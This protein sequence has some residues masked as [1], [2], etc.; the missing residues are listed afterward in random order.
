MKPE[1]INL[2]KWVVAAIGAVATFFVIDIGKLKLEKYKAKTQKEQSLLNSYLQ[3]TETPDPDLW[4]RKLRLIKI[5][6]TDSHILEWASGEE[7]FIK[8]QSALIE[9]Y[10]ETVKVTSILANRNTYNTPDW[11]EASKRYYQLY[12]ADLPYYG[13]SQP[14]IS[15][16]IEFKKKFDKIENDSDVEQW[17]A[18]N[19]ALIKL[20]KTL[21]E[22]T[23]K[24]ENK[25]NKK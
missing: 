20:A 2:L 15:T 3:A 17:R 6:S 22:E 18:M 14:V 1:T 11:I 10:R 9:L 24:L 4:L 21:K 23:K 13:E 8:E 16:M 12:W 5:F 25:H 19:I 7:K